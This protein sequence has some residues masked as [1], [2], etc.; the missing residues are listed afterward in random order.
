MQSIGNIYTQPFAGLTIPLFGTTSSGKPTRVLQFTADAETLFGAK[1]STVMPFAQAVTK[2]T[3]RAFRFMDEG[4]PLVQEIL[5]NPDADAESAKARGKEWSTGWSPYNP[6]VWKLRSEAGISGVDADGQMDSSPKVVLRSA[7]FLNPNRDLVQLEWDLRSSRP[8]R[9]LPGQHVIMD[10]RRWLSSGIADYTHMARSQGGE[11]SLNDDGVRSYTVS[12]IFEPV[13]EEGG[14]RWTTRFGL[15]LRGKPDGAVTRELF[16]NVAK[17]LD[18]GVPTD[19]SKIEAPLMGVAGEFLVPSLSSH[20]TPSSIA[21]KVSD[22]RTMKPQHPLQ[23]LYLA[24]GIG[25]TAVLAHLQS[26]AT[27]FSGSKFTTIDELP[28][29]R[30]EVTVLLATRPGEMALT[31]DCIRESLGP[32][33]DDTEPT[34]PTPIHFKI[35]LLSSSNSNAAR[36][37]AEN[38]NPHLRIVRTYN[39]RL[40][41]G[42]L[43][44]GGILG[45]TFDPLRAPVGVYAFICGTKGFSDVAKAALR[46]AGVPESRVQSENFG[47]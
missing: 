9:I 44:P 19:I 23:L 46:V 4:L 34:E 45:E 29:R 10:M 47:Y 38:P 14:T 25:M 36:S 5:P 26:L 22:T 24:N 30:V 7:K 31:E 32:I 2:F 6:A 11:Q 43:L 27:Q 28:V 3:V 18:G 17:V 20:S 8:L 15:T 40:D 13:R 16:E 41:E 33:V 39:S 21:K 37:P 42:S 1:A 12:E 35:H